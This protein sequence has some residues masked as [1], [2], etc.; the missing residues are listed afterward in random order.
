MGR[1]SCRFAADGDER[2]L[3]AAVD[4]AYP[5][6]RLRAAVHLRCNS[7]VA[8]TFPTIG[9]LAMAQSL[10]SGL[11][12]PLRGMSTFWIRPIS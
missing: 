12:A 8:A 6:A 10:S 2:I 11:T 7:R 9:L 4:L 3:A 5:A 1:C